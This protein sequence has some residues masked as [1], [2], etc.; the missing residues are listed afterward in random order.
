MY[1]VHILLF[2]KGFNSQDRRVRLQRR[3]NLQWNKCRCKS[4]WHLKRHSDMMICIDFQY[5][6][7]C[8]YL[9]LVP[10]RTCYSVFSNNY[11]TNLPGKRK[12]FVAP[13]HFPFYR[14]IAVYVK[15]LKTLRILV[16]MVGSVSIT[17]LPGSQAVIEW[18]ETNGVILHIVKVVLRHIGNDDIYKEITVATTAPPK[19]LG[20][21][22]LP[23]SPN[24]S[25]NWCDEI[26]FHCGRVTFGVAAS[27]DHNAFP[28][29]YVIAGKL[30]NLSPNQPIWSIPTGS[31]TKHVDATVFGWAVFCFLPG[32]AFQVW[33][34]EGAKTKSNIYI[35]ISYM[36]GRSHLFSIQCGG[37]YFL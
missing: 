23:A 18:S 8:A 29:R 16:L 33:W 15:I 21:H 27:K 26:L 7:A 28:L 32:P 25:I 14:C 12:A 5:P 1:K 13:S 3:S 34:S 31:T 10:L 2:L 36:E 22:E 6:S 4:S 20:F 19:I 17:Q 11:M 35:Y 24:P 37:N 9:Y 30:F